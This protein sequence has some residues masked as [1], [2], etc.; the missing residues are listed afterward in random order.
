[1]LLKCIIYVMLQQIQD[2]DSRVILLHLFVLYNQFILIFILRLDSWLTNF[3]RRNLSF[4]SMASLL[5]FC[6]IQ[7]KHAIF[8]KVIKVFGPFVWIVLQICVE[9]KN[10]KCKSLHS[11]KN[12]TI[13]LRTCTHTHKYGSQFT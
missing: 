3:L 10:F 2:I 5:F 7:K 6:I 12:K 8:N 13:D 4:K 9:E 1:M 11:L